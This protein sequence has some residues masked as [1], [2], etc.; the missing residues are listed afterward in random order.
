MDRDFN[1]EGQTSVAVVPAKDTG[2]KTFKD[3]EGKTVGVNS[4]QGSWEVE[5]KEAIAKEGGDPE[6]VKLVPVGFG[7]QATAVAS[8]N[9]DAILTAQP[10][11]A[12]LTAEGFESIGDPQAIMMG[13]DES[14]AGGIFMANSFVEENEALVENFVSTLAEGVEF[15]NDPANDKFMK[16]EIA[17]FTELPA[18]IVDATPIPNFSVSVGTADMEKWIEG[19]KTYGVIPNE[20]SVDDVLWSGAITEDKQ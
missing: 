7:D 6:N 1:E 17:A 14:T 10:I 20:P 15:C 13:S 8:G 9:V 5:L 2:I 4:L 3:L 11:L 16:K 12:L 18:E 19:M